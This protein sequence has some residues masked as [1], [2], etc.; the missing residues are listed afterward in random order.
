MG[1]LSLECDPNG[2]QCQCKPNVVG[3]RCDKCAPGTF[4]FGPEGCQ[5]MYYVFFICLQLVSDFRSVSSVVDIKCFFGEMRFSLG[6]SAF[7]S[8]I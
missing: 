1:S 8:L 5:R 3:R 6:T 4:G 2:G 7:T